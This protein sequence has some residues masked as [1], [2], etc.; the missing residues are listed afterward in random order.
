MAECSIRE[1]NIHILPVIQLQC[2][3]IPPPSRTRLLAVDSAGNIYPVSDVFRLVTMGFDF[4]FQARVSFDEFLAH[5][6]GVI[7]GGG[8]PTT[9]RVITQIH[10]CGAS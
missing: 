1:V 4:A 7:L 8:V 2:W 3:C 9:A 6:L 5:C 10:L